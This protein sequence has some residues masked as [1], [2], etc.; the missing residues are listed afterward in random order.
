MSVL[1]TGTTLRNRCHK[2]TVIGTVLFPV[3][4]DVRWSVPHLCLCHL[5]FRFCLLHCLSTSL[6]AQSRLLARFMI[7]SGFLHLVSLPNL[8]PAHTIEPWSRGDNSSAVI[9]SQGDRC[10]SI[11]RE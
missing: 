3:L 6:F 1:G 11:Q 2:L 9:F 7:M 10:S 8:L 5:D 4:R